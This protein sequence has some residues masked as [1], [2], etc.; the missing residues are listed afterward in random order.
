[1][2]SQPDK[3][4]SSR[5]S[6]KIRIDEQVNDPTKAPGA[7]LL[8]TRTSAQSF[9]RAQEAADSSPKAAQFALQK[10]L[11]SNSAN[12]A[13]IRQLQCGADAR[14]H[15][16][17]FKLGFDSSTVSLAEPKSGAELPNAQGLPG[18]LKSGIESLSGMRMD[19]VKVHL[20]SHRPAQLHAHA[21]AQGSE[22]HLGPGQE[23]HLPHEAWHV[24]QQ[25]QGR[26]RP[27]T[28]KKSG[29]INDDPNL[30][31]EADVMGSKALNTA[32]QSLAG[33]NFLGGAAGGPPLAVSDAPIQR[34]RL[35]NQYVEITLL[36]DERLRF[37]LGQMDGAD[38]G[39]DGWTYD[40]GDR[41]QM[42]RQL[43]Q[44]E[45]V[46]SPQIDVIANAIVEM[47]TNLNDQFLG[48]ETV[49]YVG[50]GGSP[51]VLV[52]SLK[53]S[54]QPAVSVPITSIQSVETMREQVRE[55]SDD[56][57]EVEP[58]LDGKLEVLV[59]HFRK[60]IDGHDA[61][62]ETMVPIDFVSSGESLRAAA[63]ILERAYPAVTV[64]CRAMAFKN[65]MAE[66]GE[67]L[68]TSE[69]FLF[70]LNDE[71]V[72]KLCRTLP[73]YTVSQYFFEH[74]GEAE[75]VEELSPQEQIAAW[76]TRSQREKNQ[77][78][79]VNTV[80]ARLPVFPDPDA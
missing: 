19:H 39:A 34:L 3:V 44:R 10:K 8:D 79:V 14:P 24:V 28:Q 80:I 47:M 63:Q 37:H 17:Q 18:A 41:E 9:R 57:E 76:N 20:N 50:I 2:R 1:M 35:N 5:V 40:E 15:A 33:E 56:E 62:I 38:Q 25:A 31:N 22:I 52:E 55:Q 27:T 16:K 61:G 53:A 66:F 32:A 75:P 58:A 13:R 72:K 73:Q 36:T 46:T 64:T 29:A 70:F 60:Y 43:A 45:A 23:K 42:E 77:L 11:M 6:Q 26:V 4:A 65:P 48:D 51:E 49:L 78:A 68:T 21:F 12:S 71:K 74:E 69:D 54:K 59:T 7:T 30:E 67:P